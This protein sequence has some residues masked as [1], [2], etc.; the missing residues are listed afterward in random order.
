MKKLLFLLLL[1]AASF[2]QKANKEFKLKGEF[3]LLKPVEMIYL[4]Y[5][6]GEERRID[7]IPYTS[8]EFKF[9][10]MI[11]EPVLA[12]LVVRY[13]LQPD[14]ERAKRESQPI[15]LEPTKM[16]VVAKDSLKVIS[17][18]GSDS[19]VDYVMLNERLKPYNEKLN[20]LYE[21]YSKQSKA[22]DQTAMEKIVTS[23]RELQKK[24]EEDVY[25]T[26]AQSHPN[27]PIGLYALKQ[28]AGY[29]IDAEKVDP[30]FQALS[31]SVKELPSAIALKEQ[32]VIAKKTAIGQPAMEF[33][34]NDPSGNPVSLSSFRGKYVLVDF[35]ASWCG[36]CRRENPNV[37]KAFQTYKDKNFTVLGV[38][39]DRPEGKE[40][41]LEA[42]E[43]DNLTWTQVSDLQYF[44]NAVAKQYG[45]RAIPQNILIDPEGIIVARNLRG[46]ELTK[47]LG[48]LVK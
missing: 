7:S 46:E 21:E 8:G 26:F 13:V 5:Y 33:T 38:S 27:S 48:E 28:Y 15:F 40:K 44:D 37:V 34:Q 35:W 32:M 20:K 25:K 2:A 1:P 19:H 9:E 29:D 16:E 30:L 3:K 12:S 47:K 24:I 11:A 6:N 45:I 4:S 18:K 14:D 17:V 41:W 43:K 23:I 31:A 10:G 42:I 36:P 39:L 22:G